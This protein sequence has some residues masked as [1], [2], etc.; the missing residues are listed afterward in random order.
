MHTHTHTHAHVSTQ[1]THVVVIEER[2]LPSEKDVE[3]DSQAPH[4][5]REIVGPPLQNLGG[6]VPGTH[7]H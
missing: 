3:D 2:R 7:A 1:R 6:N 5:H 4:I